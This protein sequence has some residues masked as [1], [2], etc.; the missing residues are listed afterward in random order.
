MPVEPGEVQLMMGVQKR[1]RALSD[2]VCGDISELYKMGSELGFGRFS[3]VRAAESL[4]TGKRFALKVVENES[5]ND[6]ENLVALEQEVKILRMLEHPYVVKLKEVVTTPDR[7][8]AQLAPAAAHKAW[9]ERALR[10]HGRDVA[11]QHSRTC[12]PASASKRPSRSALGSGRRR[13][14]GGRR[15]P[16]LWRRN[17]RRMGACAASPSMRSCARALVRRMCGHARRWGRACQR[18]ADGG[19]RPPRK[20]GGGGG[21][22][23]RACARVRARAGKHAEHVRGRRMPA[24]RRVVGRARRASLPPS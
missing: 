5:L 10:G 19:R 6:D 16:T 23:A 1:V 9:A 17:A 22:R 3:T 7:T 8:C 20:G 12:A 18:T 24:R 11:I 2:V 15:A 4:G 14:D 21:G 13:G